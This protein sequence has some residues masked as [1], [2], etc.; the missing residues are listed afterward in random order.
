MAG[1]GKG[2]WL[3]PD[4]N[5]MYPVAK[6]RDRHEWWLLD[7]DNQRKVNLRPN[8]IAALDELKAKAMEPGTAVPA[9]EIRLIGVKAGL[10]RIRDFRNNI[11]VQ[12][13]ARRGRVRDVLWSVFLGM[14]KVMSPSKFA[15]VVIHNLH[16]N[17]SNRL[18]WS[19]FQSRL[20]NDEPILREAVESQPPV[21]DIP[22]NP[23]LM[24]AVDRLLG[25]PPYRDSVSA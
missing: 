23:E 10:I 18:S 24:E 1:M 4:D 16:D 13:H 2:F 21:H 7:A 14:D 19:Q 9:D 15:E 22:A 5:T 25:E 12:F 20:V 3:D 17:D 8:T 11:V 6:F